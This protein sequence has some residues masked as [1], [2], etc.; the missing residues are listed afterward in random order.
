[1]RYVSWQDD[2]AAVPQPKRID[3]DREG[4]A[5]RLVIYTAE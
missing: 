3:A 5:I 4:L 2:A 1:L